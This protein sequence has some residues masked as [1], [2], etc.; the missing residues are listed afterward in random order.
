MER[1][2]VVERVEW[3]DFKSRSDGDGSKREGREGMV[4]RKRSNGNR[5]EE[6]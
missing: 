1:G 6:V 3:G 2:G 5:R 4:G